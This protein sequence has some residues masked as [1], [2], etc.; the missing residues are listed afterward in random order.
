MAAAT[1]CVNNLDITNISNT[2]CYG[3]SN[4]Y[5]CCVNFPNSCTCVNY[6]CFYNTDKITTLKNVYICNSSYPSFINICKYNSNFKTVK[7]TNTPVYLPNSGSYF[8]FYFSF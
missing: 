1:L 2:T 6:I 3:S 7:V 4:N 5:F 8:K